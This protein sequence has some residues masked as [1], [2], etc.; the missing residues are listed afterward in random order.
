MTDEKLPFT[1]HLE[2]LRERLIKAL[3]AVGIGFVIS[4]FFSEEIFRVLMA[5]LLKTLPPDS[6]LI[7]TG[8]TEAFFTYLK[9]SLVAGTF[10]ASP[11]IAYQIWAFIAPGLYEEEK[12]LLIPV[13][14]ASAFFFVGGSLFGYFVVF[15]FGFQYFLSFA[16]EVIKPMP[17]V[18][19]YFSFSIKLLFAF[20]ITFELPVFV[21]FLSR[22]GIVDY[23]MLKGFRKY[24]VVLTFAVAAVITPPDIL[25]QIM[26]AIP[27]IILYE[28][29]IIVAKLF[30]KKKVKVGEGLEESK[31]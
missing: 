25:S 22:L 5:P 4:Y 8:L 18:R 27:M 17:S 15:P 28:A 29:G 30:G 7:F 19:E 9:V 1:A 24:A 31:A 12:R 13:A 21:F 2:E 3:I 11:V 26:L 16:T 10:L 14:I 23:E 6:N 20:G